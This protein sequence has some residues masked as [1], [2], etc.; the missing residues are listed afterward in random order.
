[1]GCK[2]AGSLINIQNIG[3]LERKACLLVQQLFD[4]FGKFTPLRK[5][6]GQLTRLCLRGHLACQQQPEHALRDNFLA[7]GRWG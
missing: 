5:L 4:M 2:V 3:R 7:A 1:M 6:L